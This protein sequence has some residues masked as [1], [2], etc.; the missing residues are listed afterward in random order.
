MS[1]HS[2]P[3]LSDPP[4]AISSPAHQ[5]SRVPPQKWNPCQLIPPTRLNP[6]APVTRPLPI[7]PQLSPTCLHPIPPPPFPVAIIPVTS[8]TSILL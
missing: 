7:P 3:S 8:L 6:P 1:P 5:T 4:P 2:L